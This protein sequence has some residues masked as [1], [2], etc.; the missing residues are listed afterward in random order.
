MVSM[1]TDTGDHP[2]VCGEHAG[3]RHP[4]RRRRGSSPRVRG[5][6]TVLHGRRVVERIIPA[7]AG[8]TSR[9]RSASGR[10]W[11]HP[12]VCGEHI[13]IKTI[14]GHVIGSSPRVRGTPG[15]TFSMPWSL[16]IIPACAGNTFSLPVLV[17][18][19][20]DHPRVCGE[21]GRLPVGWGRCKGSSPRV[22][23]TPG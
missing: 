18:L 13:G 20:W 9:R 14:P 11:D 17:N 1:V 23:G 22:R 7:C 8:N 3:F 19:H 4:L 2:R 5:T 15:E 6:L 10:T 16:G 12:R 21:H